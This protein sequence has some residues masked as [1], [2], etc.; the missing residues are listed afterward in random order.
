MSRWKN[1]AWCGALFVTLAIGWLLGVFGVWPGASL[2]ATATDRVDSFAIA[3]GALDSEVEGVYFLDFLTGDL[4]VA[5]LSKQQNTGWIANFRRNVAKDLGVDM[6]KNPK[7]M[8]VTGVNSMRRG[9]TG[10]QQPSYAT[11]YVAELTSGKVAAYVVPWNSS[12]RQ[13]NQPQ[14]GELWLVGVA[15]FRSA[16]GGGAGA[17]DVPSTRPG[18]SH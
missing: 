11:C 13:S 7:F 4:N 16:V 10:S 2:H 3:T 9:P 14:S 1:I 12:A 5:A 18:R 6:Q 17:L 15:P 8:M